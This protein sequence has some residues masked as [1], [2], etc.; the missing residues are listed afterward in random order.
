M[1]NL[2]KFDLICHAL[3][4]FERFGFRLSAFTLSAVNHSFASA[5]PNNNSDDLS[6]VG[7][8]ESFVKTFK[9]DY[10]KLSN[11]PDSQ[12]MMSQLKTWFDDYNSYHP[13]SALGYLPPQMFREKRSAN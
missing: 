12:T 3:H 6:F 8:A 2:H 10:A 9:R 4:V 1:Q 5:E 13:H 7:M 11:R